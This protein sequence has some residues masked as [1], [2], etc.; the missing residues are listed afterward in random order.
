MKMM[1]PPAVG[2]ELKALFSQELHAFL[3]EVNGKSCYVVVI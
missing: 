3:K 2:T 1:N